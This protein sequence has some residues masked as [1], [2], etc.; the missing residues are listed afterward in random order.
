MRVSLIVAAVIRTAALTQQH[1]GVAP[2]PQEHVS[3]GSPQVSPD[4]SQIVF[5]SDRSGK[6]Q[7]Y[8]MKADGS[9]ERQLTTD[10]AGVSVGS[11][12]PDGTEI[13][14]ATKGVANEQIVVTRPDGTGR[15]VVIEIQGAQTPTWAPSDRKI[16]FT[17]GVFP[18]LHIQTIGVDGTDRRDVMPDSGFNYDATWSPDGHTIA[19]VRGIPH[20]GVRVFLMNADGT[21][22]RRLTTNGDN[23]ER[24]AWSADGRY[25]AFQ[26]STRGPGPREAYIYIADVAAMTSRRLGTHDKPQLDE[27]PSW[28]P[29]GKRLAIQSDRDGDWSI[30]VIDVRGTT[31]ARLTK[32]LGSH[33]ASG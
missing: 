5:R 13:V 14:Y 18:N 24:P 20:Q 3:G 1:P 22:Q 8:L 11:W 10:S 9:G 12:A 4:G 30:Y 15:R 27:T 19:F 21:H 23:E 28:F 31:R 17:A 25:L 32:P 7:L 16:L 6:S 2:P 33:R 26:A 29:D